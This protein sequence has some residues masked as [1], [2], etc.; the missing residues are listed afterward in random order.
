VLG[1]DEAGRSEN[2]ILVLGETLSSGMESGLR[3]RASLRLADKQPPTTHTSVDI[4][5]ASLVGPPSVY[6]YFLL[7]PDPTQTIELRRVER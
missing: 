6:S 3:H 2:H 1:G 4:N 7:H 5:F